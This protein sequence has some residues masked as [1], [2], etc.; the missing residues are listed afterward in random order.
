MEKLYERLYLDTDDKE[1][2]D[3]IKRFGNA[4]QYIVKSLWIINKVEIFKA[5]NNFKLSNS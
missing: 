3:E 4:I 2:V 1:L 5:I